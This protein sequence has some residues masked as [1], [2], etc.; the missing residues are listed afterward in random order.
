M[1][2]KTTTVRPIREERGL[3]RVQ[4]RL[5]RIESKLEELE[6]RLGELEDLLEEAGESRLLGGVA[7]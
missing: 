2:T 6:A 3:N 7:D 5:D 1:P 4:Q